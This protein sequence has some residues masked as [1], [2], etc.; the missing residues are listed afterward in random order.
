MG[1]GVMYR[2]RILGN[3][4]DYVVD[5]NSGA[6]D[7]VVLLDDESNSISMEDQN[8]QVFRYTYTKRE[9]IVRDFKYYALSGDTEWV[10]DEG[11]YR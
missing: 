8:G 2:T 7:L 1:T 5:L 3:D 11:H 6:E 10:I 4:G 9:A